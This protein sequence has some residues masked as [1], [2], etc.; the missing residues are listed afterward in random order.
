M[1]AV[2]RLYWSPANKRWIVT[3]NL[4]CDRDEIV[5]PPALTVDSTVG[6]DAHTV[7]E[8]QCAIA[9]RLQALLF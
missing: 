2:L 3:A 1:N 8:L 6:M 7:R 9:D 5:S 4:V